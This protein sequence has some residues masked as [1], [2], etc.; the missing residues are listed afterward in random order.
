MF[1]SLPLLKETGQA[2]PSSVSFND[3]RILISRAWLPQK[4]DH[5]VDF[6]VWTSRR[7]RQ[8][9]SVGVAESL[10]LFFLNNGGW[11]DGCRCTRLADAL[12]H[13]MQSNLKS[14]WPSTCNS[15]INNENWNNTMV[16]EMTQLGQ[17][18]AASALSLRAF[19]QKKTNEKALL[20]S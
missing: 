6:I 12:S 15:E 7:L 3:F 17:T 13:Q 10:L 8:A 9:G 20:S 18:P 19:Y 5:A 11:Q 2:D 14:G 16:S 1:L 4:N